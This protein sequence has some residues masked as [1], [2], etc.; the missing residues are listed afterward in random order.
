[1]TQ[2][3]IYSY[4]ALNA[5]HDSIT[6]KWLPIR[7][8]KGFN[9]TVKDCPLCILYAHDV[10]ICCPISIETKT[11]YCNNSLYSL[12]SLHQRIN[13]GLKPPFFPQPGCVTCAALI[14]EFIDYLYSL[15]PDLREV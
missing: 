9:N 6:K 1:M 13:H 10:C 5:L 11:P 3:F 8:K 4:E 14:D 12:W 2:D 7:N 15:L